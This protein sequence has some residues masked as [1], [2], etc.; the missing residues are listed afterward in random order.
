MGARPAISVDKSSVEFSGATV[1]Q[2]KYVIPEHGR[3]IHP[4]FCNQCGTNLGTTLERFPD[5]QIIN[6]GTLD[7]PDD[8][9]VT[10]E[11]FSDESIECVTHSPSHTVY[12]H[13]RLNK[14]GSSAKPKII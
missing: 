3:A 1:S 4:M 13:H 6:I 7:N 11:Y 8:V 10:M 14:D 9:E 2:F 12:H 5:A